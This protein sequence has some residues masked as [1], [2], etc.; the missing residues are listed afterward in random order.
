MEY[1]SET[2]D[3]RIHG[4]ARG[5]ERY[6]ESPYADFTPALEAPKVLDTAVDINAQMTEF[7]ENTETWLES[8]VLESDVQVLL[9][10]ID[11]IVNALIYIHN[12]GTVHRDLKP[13]NGKY[14]IFTM[15]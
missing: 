7:V 3:D 1:C 14:S 12:L 5:A 10:V 4:R 15:F 2:L 8:D 11:D 13:Q 6:S 9:D